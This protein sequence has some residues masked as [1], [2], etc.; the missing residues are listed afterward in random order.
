MVKGVPITPVLHLMVKAALRPL[1]ITLPSSLGQIKFSRAVGVA[2]AE[3]PLL[4]AVE[5]EPAE[6]EMP[7][8]ALELELLGC[9]GPTTVANVTPVALLRVFV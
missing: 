8:L 5:F 1:E 9:L 2:D 6:A 3:E 4:V 7:E